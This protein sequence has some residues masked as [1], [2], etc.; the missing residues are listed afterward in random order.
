MPAPPA[1]RVDVP[2]SGYSATQDPWSEAPDGTGLYF[3]NLT[4]VS[5]PPNTGVVTW[6]NEGVYRSATTGLPM[7]VPSGAYLTS[8]TLTG[9]Q[10]FVNTAGGDTGAEKLNGSTTFDPGDLLP[11]IGTDTAGLLSV[12]MEFTGVKA[13]GPGAIQV[14]STGPSGSPASV[15]KKYILNGSWKVTVTVSSVS[16][17]HG[18]VTGGTAVNISGSNLSVPPYTDS[19]TYSTRV[20]VG[21]T[22]DPDTGLPVGGSSASSVVASPSLISC[23]FGGA[24]S[25]I[26]GWSGSADVVVLVV[27]GLGVGVLTD[28]YTYTPALT[29]VSP[30]YGSIK[31][32]YQII[33]NGGGFVLYPSGLPLDDLAVSFGGIPGTDVIVVSNSSLMVTVPA[34]TTP[35]PVDVVLTGTVEGI[36]FTETLVHGFTYNAINRAPILDAGP[37]QTVSP[38]L[39]QTL[40]LTGFWEQPPP[41]GTITFQWTQ[42]GGPVPV[43]IVTPTTMATD[44]TFGMDAVPGVYVFKLASSADPVAGVAATSDVVRVTIP[45]PRA[46]RITELHTSVKLP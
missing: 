12:N 5:T 36:A 7:T 20:R 4:A 32:G 25:E 30:A 34:G 27:D 43:A 33:L 40:T 1:I 28:G 23:V 2:N 9:P 41:G 19:G 11:T 26:N 38:P 18:P 31:G 3:Y 21:A 37:D 29:S 13:T 42:A 24:P 10:I 16:P 14:Q 15:P 8:A 17:N 44:I 46:P 45:S 22:L 6:T 39:P 35:G